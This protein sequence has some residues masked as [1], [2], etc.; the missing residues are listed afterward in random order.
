MGRGEDEPILEEF[1]RN[2][3]SLG[4]LVVKDFDERTLSKCSKIL[5]FKFSY[6]E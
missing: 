1:L 2:F 3:L 5:T 6:F 4:D